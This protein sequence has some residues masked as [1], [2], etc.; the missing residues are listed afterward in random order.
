VI[1]TGSRTRP[2]LVPLLLAALLLLAVGIRIPA[3]GITG[4]T[5]DVYVFSTWAER[6]A[7]VGPLHFYEGSGSIYPALLYLYWPLGVAFDGDTLNVAIKALAIPF[8]VAVGLLVGL[9]LAGV[10]GLVLLARRGRGATMPL[11]P[12]LALGGL[13]ALP[14][15]L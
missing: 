11:A 6:M 2:L 3:I 9:C 7:A 10:Y 5:G 4:H 15:T 12:F 1:N 14:L 8:D 13:A